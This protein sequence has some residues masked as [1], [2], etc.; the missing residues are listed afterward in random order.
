MRRTI[1]EICSSF[2][3]LTMMGALLEN[4]SGC[5]ISSAFTHAASVPKYKSYFAVDHVQ[6]WGESQESFGYFFTFYYYI[7]TEKCMYLLYHCNWCITFCLHTGKHPGN[8]TCTA[9]KQKQPYMCWEILRYWKCTYTVFLHIHQ[10][11][12]EG[13]GVIFSTRFIAC[14]LMLKQHRMITLFLQCDGK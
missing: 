5:E 10:S 6:R 2:F 11:L 4:S 14:Q 1:R 3:L 13:C 12:D 8:P 7:Y 9:R